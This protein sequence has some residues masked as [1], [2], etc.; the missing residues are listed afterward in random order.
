MKATQGN[1]RSLR[2]PMFFAAVAG[3]ALSASG[4]LIESSSPPPCSPDLFVNWRIIE[5][6]SNA[7]L[8]CDEVPATTVRVNVSGQTTDFACPAGV[9]GGQIPYY[10]DVTGTYTV[11]VTLLDGGTVLSQTPNNAIDVDCS[12]LTSTPLIDLVVL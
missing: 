10:L 4:C 5:S 12:G 2:V 8:T 7:V 3:I 9:S 6:G 1:R 11:M